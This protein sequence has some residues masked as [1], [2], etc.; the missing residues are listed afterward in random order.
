MAILLKY[1][2]VKQQSNAVFGQFGP[3]WKESCA[4]NAKLERLSAKDLHTVGVGRYL[5]LAALGESLEDSLPILRKYR[6]RFDLVTCD[7]AFGILLENGIKADYV[8]ICDTNI[9]TRW[10]ENHVDDTKGV[11]LLATC[12]AN[13]EWTRRWKGPRY[14]YINKDSIGTEKVFLDIMGKE[15]RV[16]PAGS[17]VSNAMLIFMVGTDEFYS[18]NWS[19]YEGYFLVGYDYSWRPHQTTGVNSKV[20]KYYAFND[21]IPKRFYMNHRTSLDYNG[22]IVHTSENLL[23]SAKWMYSY[24]TAFNLPVVNCSGRGILDIPRRLSIEHCLSKISTE[25]GLTNRVRTAFNN[26]VDAHTKSKKAQDGFE[27]LRRQTWL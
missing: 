12:Y 22:D 20:G 19:G 4:F 16:I 6:D 23:F 21:P 18:A 8:Q 11:K 9:P 24:V 26:T 5:V 14:F 7:K 2:Q 10:I 27:T 3:K 17:N 25:S 15:T 1:K 13:T